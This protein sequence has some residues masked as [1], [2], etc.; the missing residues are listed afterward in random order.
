[1]AEG[2]KTYKVVVERM[3]S[4]I[5][6]IKANSELDA[7]DVA[8]EFIEENPNKAFSD[9]WTSRLLKELDEKNS[10]DKKQIEK[11]KE[12]S[13]FISEEEWW[14]KEEENKTT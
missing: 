5:L 4:K 3:Q 9:A 13:A 2:K 10:E 7:L 1:M 14:E 12:I 6:F 11:A 8:E